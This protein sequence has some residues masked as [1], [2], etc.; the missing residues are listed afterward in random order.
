MVATENAIILQSG[1]LS[2]LAN[3]RVRDK[4]PRKIRQLKADLSH[5][6]FVQLS[7]RGKGS[8]NAWQHADHPDTI[9]LSGAD[10]EDA[11]RYQEKQ[12]KHAIEAVK[13]RS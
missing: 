13:Y 4:M 9:V 6:G 10:G 1:I 8:H 12:V 7:Q 5:A 11:K 2:P 3:R